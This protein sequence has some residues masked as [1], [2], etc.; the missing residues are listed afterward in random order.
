MPRSL[1]T[2]PSSSSEL[3][4][5]VR[6]LGLSFSVPKDWEIVRHSA[7][8]EQGSLVFVDRRTQRL[9][10]S[11]TRCQNEPDLERVL[12]DYQSKERKEKGT[13]KFEKFRHGRY[14]GLSNLGP[15]G[16]QVTR[17]VRFHAPHGRLVEALFLDPK[18]STNEWIEAFL[19]SLEFECA[20]EQSRRVR[21]FDID[22]EAPSGL[23]LTKAT[24]K[25]ADVVFVFS[26]D[27]ERGPRAGTEARLRRLGM[28]ASWHDG[29]LG[30]MVRKHHPK[31][32][33]KTVENQRR[34]ANPAVVLEGFEPSPPLRRWL[35]LARCQRTL[36]W[37]SAEE[38]AVYELTTLSP[39][40]R[41]LRPTAFD[42]QLRE[43]GV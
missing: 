2:N 9:T 33:F 20:A 31:S 36:A 5:P 23:R 32:L 7:S 41:P 38:N 4:V 14:V 42:V 30:R 21:A 37:H 22:V 43:E 10:L 3:F 35:R 29:D 11:W 24:V 25:P 12:G 18:C 40:K 27:E 8:C 34:G 1:P 17:A 6:W 19:D 28:A 26:P 13:S 16:E 15:R 39:H